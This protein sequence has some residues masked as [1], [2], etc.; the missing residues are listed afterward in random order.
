MV[1]IIP[2]KKIRN[3]R[4][5]GDEIQTIMDELERAPHNIY[6]FFNYGKLVGIFKEALN[7]RTEIKK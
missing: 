4:L 5:T 6:D 2:D 3:V 7:K 1:L